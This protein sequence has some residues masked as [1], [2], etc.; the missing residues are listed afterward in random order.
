[1]TVRGD[2]WADCMD[3]TPICDTFP[4][5]GRRVS[6]QV[7]LKLSRLVALCSSYGLDGLSVRI[8]FGL[9]SSHGV[10][11]LCLRIHF[12]WVIGL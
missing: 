2:L 8:S 7:P 11:S 10:T 4:S 3:C 6:S 12:S 1:M 5:E 9:W